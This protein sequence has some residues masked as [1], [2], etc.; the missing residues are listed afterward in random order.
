MNAIVWVQVQLRLNQVH[1]NLSGPLHYHTI[2]I[3]SGSQ[4]SIKT[5]PLHFSRPS[6][7]W[8]W[9]QY[10]CRTRQYGRRNCCRCSWRRA[11]LPMKISTAAKNWWKKCC[12]ASVVMTW[13]AI[14]MPVS[15]CI[16]SYLWTHILINILWTSKW[17]QLNAE[18][19]DCL[20]QIWIFWIVWLEFL[21]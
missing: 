3:W 1:S 11:N 12:I 21:V 15:C 5:N 2:K 16:N 7:L 4:T 18:I 17:S 20:F 6:L 13:R 9:S 10:D 14:L 8:L 19:S